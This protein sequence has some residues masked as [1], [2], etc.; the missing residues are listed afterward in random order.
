M[1]TLETTRGETATSDASFNPKV[2]ADA[3]DFLP[4]ATY[5]QFTAESTQPI[6]WA[7]AAHGGAGAS[8]LSRVLAPVADAEGS[9]PSQ[10]EFPYVAIVCR[11]TRMGL[12]AAHSAVLQAQAGR[13][14]GCTLL[15]VVVVA[16]APGRVPKSLAQRVSVIEELTEVWH[17]GYETSIREA[18]IDE[19]AEWVPGDDASQS[20]GNRKNRRK[21]PA[22]ESTPADFTAVGEALFTAAFAAHT[23]KTEE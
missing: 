20:T 9:W 10:D 11:S 23:A 5:R 2:A 7:L 14:G 16:D 15:G 12:E 21:K 19:L 13:T 3:A 1:S 6:A 4:I 8:T 22:T 18:Q 17:V